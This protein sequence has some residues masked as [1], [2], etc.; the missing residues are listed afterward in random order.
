MD[1]TPKK[2]IK[3]TRDRFFIGV[4]EKIKQL[5]AKLELIKQEQ[6]TSSENQKWYFDKLYE[7]A[8]GSGI[9]QLS[10]KE[11]VTKM[12]SGAKICLDPKDVS[13]TPHLA[14]DG[15]WEE[16]ITL[17]WL[18]VLQPKYV[19][20]DIGANFGYYGLL[21]AQQI[22]RKNSRVV[23]FEAN[24]KL[25]PY[26]NKTLSINWYHEQSSVENFAVADKEG[27][28]DLHIL[29]DFI[30]SSSIHSA[31]ELN[32]YM[33][34][35]VNFE[36]QEI[37]KVS[38]TTI[39]IYCSKNKIKEIN[40]IKMDI[41]G[42]EDKAYEGMRQIVKASP[43]LTLFIEFTKLSY[44]TPKIFYDLLLS[45]FGYL[46]LIDERGNLIEPIKTDYNSVLG[47]LDDWVMMV[48]SKNKNLSS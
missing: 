25:I 47:G 19:V 29:K 21:A 34:K 8:K 36:T 4:T 5:D 40:L 39:D 7:R 9:I 22:D 10:D 37:I 13:V 43:N 33:A 18:K 48:F 42:Y 41:E 24:P 12:F 1:N 11:I 23:F 32:S 14:L 30:G 27:S 46:Y 17:A 16:P 6:A 38:A 35:R 26:I 3:K 44:K 28:L 31:E 20:F 15:I 2:I 45:D